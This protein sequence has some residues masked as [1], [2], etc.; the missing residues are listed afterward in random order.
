MSKH[1]C[2]DV[3]LSQ[4]SRLHFKCTADR[5]EIDDRCFI[6]FYAKK[7]LFK[8]VSAGQGCTGQGARMYRSGARR[9]AMLDE[10]QNLNESS[11]HLRKD[12]GVW[13]TAQT[14][15]KCYPTQAM[16]KPCYFYEAR[17]HSSHKRLEK[18]QRQC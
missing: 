18:L 10:W 14:L 13:A 11:H 2:L 15:L 5:N 7:L 1:H 6:A 9:G 4:V 16:L 8:G 17:A 12:R 3:F